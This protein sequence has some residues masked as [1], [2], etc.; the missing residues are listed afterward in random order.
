MKAISLIASAALLS[1]ATSEE[2]VS[3][4]HTQESAAQASARAIAEKAEKMR[5]EAAELNKQNQ[6]RW[7]QIQKEF[8]ESQRAQLQQIQKDRED[9]AAQKAAKD[10]A[11]KAEAAKLNAENAKRRTPTPSE[12]ADASTKQ[13]KP[14]SA[15]PVPGEPWFNPVTK[16]FEKVAPEAGND[17]G[18]SKTGAQK[19]ERIWNPAKKKFEWAVIEE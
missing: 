13:A 3:G 17:S 11:S 7:A 1:V 6:E 14:R 8:A 16:K 15:A 2:I 9:R 10:Q 4:V 19:T 18:T 12:L 5:R